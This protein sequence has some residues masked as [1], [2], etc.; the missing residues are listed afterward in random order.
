MLSSRDL[1]NKTPQ[2]AGFHVPGEWQRHS[3]CWMV[4]PL[5]HRQWEDIKA[6]ERNYADVA[7]RYT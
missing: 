3:R 7:Q 5:E 1:I 2:S 6:V 4:W